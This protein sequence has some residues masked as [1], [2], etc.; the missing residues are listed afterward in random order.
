MQL[1]ALFKSP[2]LFVYGL[3]STYYHGIFCPVLIMLNWPAICLGKLALPA[4]CCEQ[5]R[6][7]RGRV[8]NQR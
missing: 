8:P 4:G 1:E 7:H 3:V 6:I 5:L 2:L